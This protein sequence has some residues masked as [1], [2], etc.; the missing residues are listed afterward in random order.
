MRFFSE[1]SMQCGQNS[2]TEKSPI[3]RLLSRGHTSPQG[4]LVFG[5]GVAQQVQNKLKGL[6]PQGTLLAWHVPH[7]PKPC[8]KADFYD[9]TA[10][11][12]HRGLRRDSRLSPL[13]GQTPSLAC[14]ALAGVLCDVVWLP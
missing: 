5:D 2:T 8:L 9:S 11:A 12:P 6:V 3:R 7:E 10:A 4:H 1:T 14:H 13:S